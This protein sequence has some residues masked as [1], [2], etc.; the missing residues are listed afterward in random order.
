[1]NSDY[2]ARMDRSGFIDRPTDEQ[3][4]FASL[5]AQYGSSQYGSELYSPEELFWMGYIYRYWVCAYGVFSKAVYKICNVREIHSVYYAYHTLDPL[6]AVQRLMEAR[7]LSFQ[8]EEQI[9]A[10]VKNLRKI[11]SCSA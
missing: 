8:E 1:M 2:A 5:D 10:G 11:R 3:E 7:G 4:A 9:T 6:Q